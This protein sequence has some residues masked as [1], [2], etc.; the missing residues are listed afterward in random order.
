MFAARS[1]STD[2]TPAE[3]FGVFRFQ[4]EVAG[5]SYVGAI[6]TVRGDRN[7]LQGTVGADTQ[8]MLNRYLRLSSLV[9]ATHDSAGNWR[10]ARFGGLTWSSDRFDANAAH[11]D[12]A[13]GFT[14]AL[15][16]VRRQDRQLQLG[17]SYK[18][19]P[20][21]GPVRQFAISPGLVSH[22][23]R[24]GALLTREIEFEVETEFQS[25]DELEVSLVEATERLPE[26]F[27]MSD[28]V[29][30]P[31]SRFDWR[32]AAI[33]L[34]TFE[35]R[36]VSGSVTIETGGF[37][38]GSRT[39][40]EL[41]T[42]VR[43]GSHVATAPSYAF[44]DVSLREGRFRTHLFGVRLDAS[45]SRNL[46]TSAFVQYDSEGQLASAQVRL[47]WILRNIDNFYVVFNQTA[48]TAGSLAGRINRSVV[49][50][51]TYSLHR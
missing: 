14:P 48:F 20:S 38:S 16:F 11:V 32:A 28:D 13:P 30:V 33:D 1:A 40:V 22:H 26:P 15:G 37:Y 39:S 42:T 31:A 27:E 49:A 34:R 23:D 12:I 41:A 6:G 47:N 4:R 43:A 5:R 35:D 10:W 51:I 19:R 2:S 36:P 7:A 25:G 9:A 18:P 17:V 50:K 44:N 3:W 8:M 24:Q 45:F 21:S 29:V 46:L